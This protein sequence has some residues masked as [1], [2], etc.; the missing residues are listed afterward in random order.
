MGHIN[1]P[2]DGV[3]YCPF[4]GVLAI[5]YI[6]DRKNDGQPT[7]LSSRGHCRPT[8]M[9]T[10]AELEATLDADEGDV[11]AGRVAPLEPVLARMRVTAERIRRERDLREATAHK[12]A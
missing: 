11:D 8:I 1:S 7:R 6:L 2:I 5:F 10:Q 3:L 4:Y 9:P 12:H